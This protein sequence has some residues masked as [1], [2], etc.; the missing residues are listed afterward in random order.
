MKVVFSYYAQKEFED[1]FA[2][3][4]LQSPGLGERF[5]KELRNAISRINA[6]PH[7]WPIESS[8]I[9]KCLLVRF[10]FKLLYSI[11]EDHLFIIAVAHLH[12]EPNYWVDRDSR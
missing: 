2:Y 5:Q 12:R 8:E 4:E 10:P 11:E 3:Y 9:R 6:F 7:G 1:A